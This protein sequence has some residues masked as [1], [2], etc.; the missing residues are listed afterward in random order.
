[1]ATENIDDFPGEVFVEGK[2]AGIKAFREMLDAEK[3]DDNNTMQVL[4]IVWKT[5][6]ALNESAGNN[7]RRGTAAFKFLELVAQSLGHRAKHTSYGPWLDAEQ[8]EAEVG[9]Q[10]IMRFKN[11][12]KASQAQKDIRFQSFMT[13]ITEMTHGEEIYVRIV[14]E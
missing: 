1:M 8:H 5:V 2:I 13:Q 7:S 4:E 6:N 10:T 9:H 14:R 12:E 3:T 11:S